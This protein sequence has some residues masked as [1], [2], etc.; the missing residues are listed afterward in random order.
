M[1]SFLGYITLCA[2]T[3]H[4]DYMLT[5]TMH[6]VVERMIDVTTIL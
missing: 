1:E 4:Y 3:V 6:C 2:C 5:I